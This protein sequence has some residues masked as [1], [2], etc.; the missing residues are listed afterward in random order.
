[1]QQSW[2]RYTHGCQDIQNNSSAADEKSG[3]EAAETATMVRLNYNVKQIDIQPS[4]VGVP[5][6]SSL[7]QSLGNAIIFPT[8]STN[9][10]M[11]SFSPNEIKS[12]IYLDSFH[13]KMRNYGSNFTQAQM[14]P[15]A[16]NSFNSSILSWTGWERHHWSNK[17][18]ALAASLQWKKIATAFRHTPG[19]KLIAT[20]WLPVRIPLYSRHVR[21]TGM[22]SIW[23]CTT[24]LFNKYQRAASD[25]LVLKCF[26]TG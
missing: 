17:L 4:L 18:P 7:C 11:C 12:A 6:H 3:L 13:A 24:N 8:H 2:I 23:N 26:N 20:R 10:S 1:M 9:H 19:E 21:S 5:Y 22:K 25:G 15:T 14:L 16:S